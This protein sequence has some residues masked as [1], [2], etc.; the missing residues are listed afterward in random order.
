MS[1]NSESVTIGTLSEG[2]PIL[3]E[4]GVLN[5]LTMRIEFKQVKGY[6]GPRHTNRG[7]RERVIVLRT[8]AGARHGSVPL[9]ASV[10]LR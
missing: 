2:T 6:V 8:K 1:K 5:S 4:F 9:D 7:G 10:K 3:Y